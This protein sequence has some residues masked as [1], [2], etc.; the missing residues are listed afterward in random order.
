MRQGGCVRNGCSEP[1]SS[2][3]SSGA[4]GWLWHAQTLPSM[5]WVWRKQGHAL[6]VSLV[7]WPVQDPAPSGDQ[8]LVSQMKQG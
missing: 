3:P 2:C 5:A 1:P 4:L 7:A 8:K 6:Q